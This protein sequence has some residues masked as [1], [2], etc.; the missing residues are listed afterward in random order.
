MATALITGASRGI[1]RAVSV[2]LAHAGFDIVAVARDAG[3]LAT[4][5]VEVQQIGRA[6]RIIPLDL[7]DAAA[8]APA[9]AD[10]DVD[11]LVN[12]AGIGVITP[13]MQL[14]TEDWQR[15]I[16]VNVNALFHVTR[17]LVP[18]MSR[19]GSGHICTIG[20][21]ASRSAFVGGA[22]YAGTKAF[23]TAWSESLMLELRGQGIKVSVVMPGSVA[24]E[25]NGNEP[26]AK[27]DWKLQPDDV[28]AAVV[29]LAMT[30]PSVLI[31]RL[32][33]RTLSVPSKK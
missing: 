20:S 25:F 17:A 16:D 33:I 13:M 9:L 4:L 26:G 22:C 30:P 1:G 8:I 5:A 32:E 19:R 23:V 12:N 21:I 24:S 7:A 3:D 15:M 27:D 18:A 6:C 10:L 11:L 29:S 2:A 31:H 14:A 28:A